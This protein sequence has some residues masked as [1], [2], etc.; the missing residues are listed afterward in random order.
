[1]NDLARGATQPPSLNFPGVIFG[2]RETPWDLNVLLYQG[3][4]AVRFKV[5]QKLIN[6]GRLGTP[7]VDRFDLVAAFHSEI[8]GAFASG[9]SRETTDA[10]VSHVRKLFVFA[11]SASLPLTLE[12]I[13][14]TYLTWCDSL[15][16]RTMVKRTHG[17][18]VKGSAQTHLANKSAFSYAVAVGVLI[19][20][21]L[22]RHSSIVELIRI[23]PEGH[24]KPPVG[25]VADKQNLEET[26]AFGHMVQDLCDGLT[27]SVVRDTPLPVRIILRTG[28]E[29]VRSGRDNIISAS[30]SPLRGRYSLA[31]IRI[32]A[33]LFMFIG[34]TGINS[35]Q[36]VGA[37]LQNFFY[38]SHLDGYQVKDYKAR[39]QGTVLFEIYKD[40]K[41]HFERYLEWRR[42]LFPTSTELFPFAG[43]EGTRAESKFSG[44]RVRRICAELNIKYVPP[45]TLRNTR[46][47]WLLR[48]SADPDLTAEMS[49]HTKK[50]LLGVY[51]RPSM[52]RA[53][54]EATLFWEKIDPHIKKTQSVAPGSCTGI[55]R[56]MDDMPKNA[57]KADCNKPAGCL[58]CS[59]HRD[60]DSQ[61]YIWAL[62]SFKHLKVIELSKTRTL[63]AQNDPPPAQ[64]VIDRI[65][66]KLSW[67]DGSNEL[68]KE[69]VLEAEARIE[70]GD[71]HPDFR[72]EIYVLEGNA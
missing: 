52:Q 30:A 67:F 22:D 8:Q 18:K 14:E 13:V 70:E 26:F 43:F 42:Q 44:A 16:H 59:N 4:A 69:W 40:Y 41:P 7:L 60:V 46:V 17:I 48:K 21:F 6:E 31:N 49:Q 50:T 11:E 33:E 38:V 45:R 61:D 12:H 23:R 10:Q 64:V 19:D 27:I 63:R 5:A 35:A 29:L 25:F 9:G 58:W 57:P 24:R 66:G 72:T 37:K 51:E 3:G 20:R 56:T 53:I 65:N 47:N 36:A 2:P 28:Q 1:M 34:Q 62:T 39:R 71:F 54:I 68:R 15:Y 55:P 32:E